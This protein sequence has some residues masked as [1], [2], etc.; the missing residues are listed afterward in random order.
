MRTTPGGPAEDAQIQ[1]GDLIVEV[2]QKP[3]PYT[4]AFY[5]L[6]KEERTYL[7]RVRRGDGMTILSLD[8][9]SRKK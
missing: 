9:S 6:F 7:L 5:S 3:V 4:A 8:L 2:D 1:R